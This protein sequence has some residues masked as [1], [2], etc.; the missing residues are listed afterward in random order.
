MD[1][2]RLPKAKRRTLL[3]ACFGCGT[4]P[5]MQG[6][7][8]VIEDSDCGERLRSTCSDSGAVAVQGC[9]LHLQAELH[10]IDGMQRAGHTAE[11]AT[12]AV[13][14]AVNTSC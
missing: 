11:T 7:Y 9:H 10:V 2:T 12:M 5:T 6:W 1:S 8:K 4:S 14:S 3:A 13:L